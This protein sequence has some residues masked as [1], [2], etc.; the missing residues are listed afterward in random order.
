M[1][2]LEPHHYSKRQNFLILKTHNL[3]AVYWPVYPSLAMAIFHLHWNHSWYEAGS[4][5]GAAMDLR[6]I[7]HFN[8]ASSKG[9]GWRGG[10]I[11]S[12]P[13]GGIAAT[14]ATGPCQLRE[15]P[16]AWCP[17]QLW[18]PWILSV[19]FQ[20]GGCWL[21]ATAFQELPRSPWS[22]DFLASGKGTQ[23]TCWGTGA[24]VGP[25]TPLV[26]QSAG[27][28]FKSHFL[29]CCS[30]PIMSPG[31]FNRGFQQQQKKEA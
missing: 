20:G 26:L 23:S 3:S 22:H 5:G 4:Q 17:Q 29:L 19:G 1:D 11:V 12:S 15:A 2:L 6:A 24:T 25:P 28:C 7:G 31:L 13:F 27:L 30:A 16:G 21:E 9:A 10:S 18:K 8:K 14:T